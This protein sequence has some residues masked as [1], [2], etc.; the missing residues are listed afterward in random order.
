MFDSVDP[1]EKSL[2][3]SVQNERTG[4]VPVNL[5]VKIFTFPYALTTH[6][7]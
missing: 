3:T 6:Y 1:L 7:R 2:E 4:K 5:R